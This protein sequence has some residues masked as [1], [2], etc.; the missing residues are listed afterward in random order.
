MGRNAAHKNLSLVKVFLISY[1]PLAMIFDRKGGGNGPS[2]AELEKPFTSPLI[3]PKHPSNVLAGDPDFD[4]FFRIHEKVMWQLGGIDFSSVKP[5]LLTDL[6]IKALRGA[7]L[8]ESHNP[9]YTS[10]ILDYYRNDRP[11]TS[12]VVTWAYEEMKHYEVLLAYLRATHKLNSGELD[13]LL[14]QTR[15]GP[16]GD[17]AMGYTRVQALTYTVLQ[18]Q[19]TGRFYKRF[20][21]VTKEPILQD[22]LRTISGDEY[23]HCQYY[24]EKDKQELAKDRDKGLEEVDQILRDFEMPGG[25][26][27]PDYYTNVMEPGLQ[28]APYDIAAARELRDKVAQLTGRMHLLKLANDPVL[29]ARMKELG[30]NPLSLFV[31]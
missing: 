10:R 18:E 29:N 6:D 31:G 13:D 21:E 25:T 9:V 23:R 14:E 27:I 1:T 8:V 28:I 2:Q 30:I 22:I 7:M 4:R 26:F 11:M 3:V 20:A 19:T 17:E 5:E 16:W 15:S 12:F 24:L